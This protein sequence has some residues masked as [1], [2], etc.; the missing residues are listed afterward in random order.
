[1]NV[2]YK[3]GEWVIIDES[4][5]SQQGHGTHFAVKFHEF[6]VQLDKVGGYCMG[7]SSLWTEIKCLRVNIYEYMLA[8]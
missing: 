4:E 2:F 8:Q 7:G 1:M 6:L 5:S 3:N